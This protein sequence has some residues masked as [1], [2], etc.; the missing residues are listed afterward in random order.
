MGTIGKIKIKY[1]FFAFILWA[2]ENKRFN[3]LVWLLLLRFWYGFPVASLWL[4]PGSK[5]GKRCAR[6][7]SICCPDN[8][9]E[10]WA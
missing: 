6:F 3:G 4:P 8:V 9:S 1:D 10:G 2:A 5:A 7:L